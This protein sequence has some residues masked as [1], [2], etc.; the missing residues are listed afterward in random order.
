MFPSFTIRFG[1]RCLYSGLCLIAGIPSKSRGKDLDGP[2]VAA[3]AVGFVLTVGVTLWAAYYAKRALWDLRKRAVA[4]D[5]VLTAFS[6][7]E[8]EENED[9]ESGILENWDDSAQSTP[10]KLVGV[11]NPVFDRSVAEAEQRGLLQDRDPSLT[12]S[13]PVAERL[14]N[15]VALEHGKDDLECRSTSGAVERQV[16]ADCTVPMNQEEDGLPLLTGQSY[17]SMHSSAVS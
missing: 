7:P 1:N 15:R 13:K 10:V 9:E 5:Q 4:R 6:F 12:G 11:G 14:D 17:S 2:L 16:M 3:Y 8:L